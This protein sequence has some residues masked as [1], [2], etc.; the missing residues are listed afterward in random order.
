MEHTAGIFSPLYTAQLIIRVSYLSLPSPPPPVHAP[1]STKHKEDNN[2]ISRVLTI[3]L[4]TTVVH[5]SYL[6][7]VIEIWILKHPVLQAFL[8]VL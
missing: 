8:T 5:L 7:K 1:K 6:S 4:P 2:D 3:Y